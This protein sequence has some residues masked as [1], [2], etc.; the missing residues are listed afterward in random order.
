MDYQEVVKNARGN[1]GPFCKAC[2]VCNGA[3]CKNTMPGPGAK[4]V[5]ILL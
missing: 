2:S 1:I 3:A 5:G 4:G